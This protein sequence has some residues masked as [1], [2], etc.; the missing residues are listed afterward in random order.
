M[1]RVGLQQSPSTNIEGYQKYI[2]GLPLNDDPSLFGL[3]TNANIS[4]AMSETQTCLSERIL[5][6]SSFTPRL[7][8]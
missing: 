4:Y 5:Y 3:H 6:I 1:K 2:R 7:C 8:P